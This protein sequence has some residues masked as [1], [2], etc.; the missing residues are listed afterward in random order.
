MKTLEKT[1][2]ITEA[3]LEEFNTGREKAL[4]EQ[5]LRLGNGIDGKIE[6]VLGPYENSRESE[7]LFIIRY[8]EKV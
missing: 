4:V 8:Q 7:M 2:R 3:Q 6:S 5:M 1:F